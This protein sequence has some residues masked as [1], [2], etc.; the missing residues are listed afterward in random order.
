MSLKTW[1]EEFYPCEAGEVEKADAVEHSLRKWRGLREQELARHEVIFSSDRV[2]SDG[3]ESLGLGSRS[4]ALCK[5]YED[6]D[7]C[8]NCASCPITLATGYPCDGTEEE[9][10]AFLDYED[11]PWGIFTETQ[12]PEPMI[13]ALQLAQDWERAQKRRCK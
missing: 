8:F 11:S 6:P 7:D 4:C 9:A 5:W 13:T 10:G 1:K 12:D 2:I 3:E